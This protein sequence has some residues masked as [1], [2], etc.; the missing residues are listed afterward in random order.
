[1]KKIILI[2]AYEPD[3]NLLQLLQMLSG[4]ECESVVVNDGSNSAYAS[5]FAEAES[6][7]A[8]LTHP[9]NLGKG[10]GIKTGLRYIQDHF[11]SPFTVVTADADGQHC[12]PDIMRVA[13]AAEEKPDHLILGSRKIEKQTPL[14]SRFGNTITRLVF[15][16]FTG[17]RIYDT[18]TG[19]RGFSHDLI[20]VL[21]ATPGQRYEY[22][23]NVLMRFAKER[24]PVEEIWI[25]TIYMDGNSASHFDTVKD[26]CRIYREILKFS[27]SSFLSFLVDYLLFRILYG[28]FGSLASGVVLANVSARLVSA[29]VNYT[30][31]RRAVFHSRE[32]V[33]ESLPR[34]ALLAVGILLVNTILLKGIIAVGMHAGLAK[35][36]V[37]AVM[38]VVSWTVQ[39]R[40]IFHKQ[41]EMEVQAP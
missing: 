3:R 41:T 9:K 14:R 23:M 13:A 5:L 38:F 7:A 20:P 32:S 33:S 8:V 4:Q 29:G 30:L 19:L 24:R 12:V 28:F 2:P 18:Q 40:L 17:S 26:S 22:E 16:L 34:Y 35:L 21:L 15:R 31:N 6:Y 10:E 11:Q 27:G 39:R 37:E 36:A 1:M 25:R